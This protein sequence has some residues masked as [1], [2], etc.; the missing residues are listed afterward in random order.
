[1]NDKPIRSY[2]ASEVH[3]IVGLFQDDPELTAEK[4]SGM[5]FIADVLSHFEEMTETDIEEEVRTYYRL[6]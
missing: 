2:T 5:E 6:K 1:M 4:L 3:E